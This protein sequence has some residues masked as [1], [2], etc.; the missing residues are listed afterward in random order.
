[1]P[2]D[3]AAGAALGLVRDRAGSGLETSVRTAGDGPRARAQV[4]AVQRRVCGVDLGRSSCRPPQL[5]CGLVGA[6]VELVVN[7]LN[8]S[9]SGVG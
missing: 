8:S 5:A 4:V 1:M 9:S 7:P 3:A 6:E 2:S